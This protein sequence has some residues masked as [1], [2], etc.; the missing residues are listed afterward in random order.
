MCDKDFSWKTSHVNR[1][2]KNLKNHSCHLCNYT[3]YTN[4][5]LKRHLIG[6]LAHQ[7]VALVKTHILIK[8]AQKDQMFVLVFKITVVK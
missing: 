6:K 1:I 8:E 5:D 7:N 3:T 4:Q 2:H